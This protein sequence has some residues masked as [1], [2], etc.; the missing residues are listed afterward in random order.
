MQFTTQIPIAYSNQPIDYNSRV[1]CLGSCFAVNIGQKFDYFK[2][3]NTTNPFGILFSP[4]ALEKFIGFAV[5][6][7]QFIEADIFFHNERWHS[8]DAHSDLSHPDKESLLGNLNSAISITY[9]ALQSA[10]H[11]I[12][13]LGTAWVYKYNQTDVLVANCHKVPQKEFTKQLLSVQEIKSGLETIVSLI[14]QI[15]PQAHITFTI[16]PVRHIKDGF[17]ENQWSK[18]NLISALQQTLLETNSQSS[19]KYFPSYEI[20]M[21]ELRDYRFYAEDMIHPNIIAV[22]YIWER[23]TQVYI[24][25]EA[26]QTMQQVESLQKSLQHRPFNPDSAQHRAFLDNLNQKAARLQQQYP[27]IVF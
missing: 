22:N 7:K 16:S 20:M 23:F 2:F 17:V 24:A 21:D 3:R 14:S 12:I 13:T 5:N 8:F 18:S 15:N 4:S 26:Q 27:H 25:P 19:V 11:I 9:N 10:S 6:K 1:V